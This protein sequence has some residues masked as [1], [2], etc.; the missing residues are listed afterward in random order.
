[1]RNRL[2]RLALAAA[3]VLGTALTAGP[4][5]ASTWHPATA[6]PPQANIFIFC[7]ASGNYCKRDSNNAST[8]GN[9]IVEGGRVFGPATES[10][11]SDSGGTFTWQGVVYEIGVLEYDQHPGWCDGLDSTDEAVQ[12][13][14]CNGGNGTVWG[15]GSLNGADIFVSRAATQRYNNLQLLSGLNDGGDLAAACS[16]CAGW[17][18]RWDHPHN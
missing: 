2:I 9:P 16:G 10:S 14:R 4:A 7:E 13:E 3:V 5:T 11:W 17:F 12:L 8:A 1:M 18:Q 15:I 6:A